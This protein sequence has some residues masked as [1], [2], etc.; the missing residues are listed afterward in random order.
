MTHTIAEQIIVL[1][2]I[3]VGLLFA[4]LLFIGLDLWAGIRKAKARGMKIRSDKLQRTI[5]KIS[6]YYNTVLA[7]VVLDAVQITGCVFL[8]I[9]NGWTLYTFPLF[10][11]IGIGYVATVEIKSIYEPA[12]AKEAKEQREVTALAKAIAEHRQD[13]KEIAEAIMNYM[14]KSDKDTAT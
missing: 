7:M 4:P 3:M 2:W 5:N 14:N 13:P 8:H 1:T 10:T 9:Y 11:L 6:R 12:D